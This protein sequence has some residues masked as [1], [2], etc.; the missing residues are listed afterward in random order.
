MT[1]TDP[2]RL[3]LLYEVARSVT[4]FTQLDPLLRFAT[5][6]ARELLDAEGCAVLLLDGARRELYFPV[7]SQVESRSATVA[8]LETLRFP[9]HL[10]V[11][12]WA[13]S[14]DESV[15]VEDA[16]SDPRFYAGV[17][18][19]TTQTTRAILCVP[20]RTRTGNIGV[21]EVINPL[22]ERFTADD[23]VFLETLAADIA[24]ACEKAQ[25]Y[26]R[27]RGE[28]I[29]L[30][31]ALH[32]AGFGVAALGVV[33]AIG[34]TYTHLAW[35]LPLDELPTRPAIVTAVVLLVLGAALTAVARGWLVQSAGE[36]GAA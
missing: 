27:L 12:G 9:A 28:T 15:M 20:L 17:D 1:T 35:A 29:A 34:G 23:L 5:R 16:A 36:I 25:L 8:R 33:F 14:H 11:A 7:A 13:L 31:Q 24:I 21:L 22:H 19:A 3:Q 26:E 6:R 4:T 32:A 30:R 2:R 18:R 10:G